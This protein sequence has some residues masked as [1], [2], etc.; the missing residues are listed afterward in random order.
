MT[1]PAP[2]RLLPRPPSSTRARLLLALALWTAICSAATSPD[3]ALAQPRAADR[4]AADAAWVA[5][6]R[7]QVER[8]EK[9]TPGQLGVYVKRL[10]TGEVFAHQADRPWY[11]ASSAKLPIAIAVLQ[12]VEAGRLREDQELAVQDGDKVDGSGSVVW[13][14][15][16]TRHDVQGLLRRMLMESDNTAANMLLRSAG[17]DV[18]AR[19][20]RSLLGPRAGRITDF[21][22][23]RYGVYAE[24]HSDARKL[25]HEDLVRIAGAPQGPRRVQ[26]LARALGMP[27]SQLQVRTMDEAYARFYRRGDNTAP[28][29]DY[30]AM[31]E[32]LVRGQLVNAEH[33]QQLYK[34]LKFDTYDAYRL[35]AGLPRTVRFIHKT[36][37][38]FQR[39][40]HMGVIDPQD[41]GRRAIIVATCAE[42]LDEQKQAGRAFEAL[43]RAITQTAI[44][45]RG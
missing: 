19:R 22:E 8:I 38:Q 3:A 18:V 7:Q 13:Q 1:Y 12:E 17:H 32:R 44:K 43:G 23:V 6:L 28:L 2:P 20:A 33:Q 40:C 29:V 5:A 41:G 16:G 21:A 9:A 15:N 34:D 42:G 4:P 26:A 45:A 10:D 35:E 36:G 30:G 25:S 14:D 27:E 24:F 39:A 37:T 11:L 31:L